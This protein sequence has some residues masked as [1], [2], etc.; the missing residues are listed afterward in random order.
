MGSLE[1]GLGGV[2]A[3]EWQ[4][5]PGR[6]D[7]SGRALHLI[8]VGHR[9]APCGMLTRCPAEG[10]QISPEQEVFPLA[11]GNAQSPQRPLDSCPLGD[12]PAVGGLA[13]QKVQERTRRGALAAVRLD[14]QGCEVIPAGLAQGCR[15]SSPHASPLRR[16]RLRQPAERMYVD[17]S[18]SQRHR[19][20]EDGPAGHT[21]CPPCR[22]PR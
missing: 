4:Q 9:G 3:W 21:R 19:R 20:A 10:M 6:R 17:S 11:E 1:Q 15:P 14:H 2:R 8:G 13:P 5:R 16:Q 7:G 12:A 22:Q 18:V